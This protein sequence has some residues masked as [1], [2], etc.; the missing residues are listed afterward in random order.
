[1]SANVS[2]LATMASLYTHIFSY[3]A[4]LR[5]TSFRHGLVGATRPLWKTPVLSAPKASSR[6]LNNRV[7]ASRVA[8][9]ARWS[10]T[11]LAGAGLAL[12]LYQNL[13]NLNCEPGAASSESPPR[14]RWASGPS[15]L[16]GLPPPPQSSVNLYELTFGTVCGVC[17][18]LFVKKGLKALAFF[19]GGVFV[20]LQYLG[21]TSIIK[22]DWPTAAARFEGLFYATKRNGTK[23]PP[24]VYSMWRWLVDFL[25]ADFQPRASFIAGFA[26]GIRIG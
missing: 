7:A 24:T 8:A 14:S 25:T 3:R 12:S 20:L 2:G 11:G 22:I 5:H 26:L 21:S 23:R 6:P 19:F 15:D 9:V 18:G 4:A 10:G 1:M 13:Q 16:S 17:A